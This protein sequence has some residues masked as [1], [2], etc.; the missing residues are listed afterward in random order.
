MTKDVEIKGILFDFDMTL[1]DSSYAIHRCINLL[2]DYIGV[3]H[4][5]REKVLENIGFTIED[6]YRNFWG[7]FKQEWLDYYREMFRSEEQDGLLLFPGVLE[8]L[9]ILREQ[10]IKVGVAS[11]RYI[12]QPVLEATKLAEYL[13]AS[14]GLIDVENAKPEPDI[15]YKGF[16]QLDVSLENAVYV[17]DTD[18]DMKTTIAAG[19][20]GIGMTT[21]NFSSKSLKKF[22]AW[23]V[24]DDVREILAL[25]SV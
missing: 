19:V 9:S 5:S 20:R 17:G 4:V 3:E 25:T 2:A 8:T 10:E 18:I 16:E 15:L 7:D 1:V 12:I 24:M 13:D 22:G 14:V 6:C 23:K 11:N 21:G